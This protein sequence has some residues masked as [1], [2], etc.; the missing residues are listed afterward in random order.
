M[1]TWHDLEGLPA[2]LAEKKKKILNSNELQPTI[3]APKNTCHC[4]AYRQERTRNPG[5]FRCPIWIAGS[6]KAAPQ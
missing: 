6:A 2:A 4:G 1:S 5:C 3:D